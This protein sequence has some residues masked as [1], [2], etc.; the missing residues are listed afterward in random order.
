MPGNAD[1]RRA[2]DAACKLRVVSEYRDRIAALQT[3][4]GHAISISQDGKERIER[5]N[6]FAYALGI[7]QHQTYIDLVDATSD[8]AVIDSEFVRYLIDAGTLVEVAPT[9]AREGDVVIYFHKD[10]PTH[11]GA[12]AALS[13][14]TTV[15]SKWGG[16]EIH[17]HDIWEVPA[18]YGDRVRVYRQIDPA[19]TLCRV[20]ALGDDERNE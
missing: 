6:C 19:D 20:S 1:L 2:L 5:F 14:R 8:S 16:N 7:W 17:Q 11:A 15:R 10:Q 9:E 12:V 3:Q 4:Y 13:E 18:C